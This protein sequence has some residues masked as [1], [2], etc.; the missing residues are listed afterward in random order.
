MTCFD[1]LS[2][3]ESLLTKLHPMS[4]WLGCLTRSS[5]ATKNMH[6]RWHSYNIRLRLSA[7]NHP[8]FSNICDATSQPDNHVAGLS[9]DLDNSLH[10]S[11]ALLHL[12]LISHLLPRPPASSCLNFDSQF[13]LTSKRIQYSHS[14]DIEQYGR[15]TG[16]RRKRYSYCSGY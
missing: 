5:L 16:R 13:P 3:L 2:S 6:C 7:A 9:P 14:R 12:S 1:R 10:G 8:F 4:W 15:G 11:H